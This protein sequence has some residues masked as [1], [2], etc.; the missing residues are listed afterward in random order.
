MEAQELF[1]TGWLIISGLI[2]AAVVALTVWWRNIQKSRPALPL[3]NALATRGSD[4]AKLATQRGA[5][6]VEDAVM[7]CTLCASREECTARVRVGAE[8]PEHCPNRGFVLDSVHD[9][10]A[11]CG[12]RTPRA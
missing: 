4:E 8:P 3:W 5:D 11:H 7:R 1:G 9:T 12:Q 6:V 2:T 10:A